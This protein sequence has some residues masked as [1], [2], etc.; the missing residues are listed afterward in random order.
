MSGLFSQS[1]GEAQLDY[2]LV[3][4]V[5]PECFC[6][7]LVGSHPKGRDALEAARFMT[8]RRRSRNAQTGP[9]ST[10]SVVH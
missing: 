10:P 5:T 2:L 9:T 1:T 8:E 3:V 6:S 4:A 7:A